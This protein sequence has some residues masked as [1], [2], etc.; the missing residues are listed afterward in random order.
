MGYK[1]IQKIDVTFPESEA[2][3]L[4]NK[5]DRRKQD[6]RIAVG[7]FVNHFGHDSMKS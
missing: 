6:Y 1:L 3:E 5:T 2:L 4:F 7:N